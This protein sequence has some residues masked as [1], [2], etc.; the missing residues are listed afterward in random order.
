MEK[1]ITQKELLRL[2]NL[3]VYEEELYKNGCTSVAGVDEVG[4]GPL[5][6]PVAAACVILPRGLLIP[7]L[8]DSKK[9]SEKKRNEI[10]KVVEEKAVCINIAEVDW[11]TIDEINILTATR[12]AMKEAVAGLNITPGH[13]LVDGRAIPD[14]AFDHTAIVGGDGKSASIAAASVIAKV[15]RDRLMIEYD[16]IYPEYGFARH[17]G[18]GTAAHVEA[19]KKYG[20]CPIHRKTFIKN[21]FRV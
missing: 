15:Y 13:V 16:D 17:K 4:R 5:A 2:K 11:R 21:I 6:G 3:W 8:D 10:T 9:L 20:P 19:L 14:A 7:G 18:Y 1:E 12:R